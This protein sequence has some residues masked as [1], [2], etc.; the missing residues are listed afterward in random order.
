MEY[1]KKILAEERN[2]SCKK[3]DDELFVNDDL[4]N[5]KINSCSKKVKK[6]KKTITMN[7]AEK[8]VRRL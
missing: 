3:L 7:V 1:K 4:D 6:T 5:N 8:V 2:K